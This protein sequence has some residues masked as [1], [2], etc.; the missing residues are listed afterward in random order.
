MNKKILFLIIMMIVRQQTWVLLIYNKESNYLKKIR[1][2][3][4][5]GKKLI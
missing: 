3:S 4:I 5:L 1:Q 2:N